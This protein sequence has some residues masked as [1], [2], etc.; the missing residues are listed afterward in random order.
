M[1]C[2]L[3]NANLLLHVTIRH[4]RRVVRVALVVRVTPCLF[5][6]DGRWRC[7]IARENKFSLLCSGFASIT[8]TTYGKTVA[9]PLNTCGASRACRDVRIAPCCPTSA[10]QHFTTFSS[11]IMQGLHMYIAC[12]VVSWREAP[13]GIWAIVNA[14][15]FTCSA[16]KKLSDCD[17]ARIVNPVIIARYTA[18]E[19]KCE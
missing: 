18:A 13:S 16:L 4:A 11:A 8:G 19:L 9:T 3:K 14:H 17:Y 12:C 6:H 1:F 15:G 10:T 5:Q 7:S 2:F